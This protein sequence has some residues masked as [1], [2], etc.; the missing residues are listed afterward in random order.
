[1]QCLEH[2]WCELQ[3]AFSH[4]KGAWEMGQSL[5]RE[6]LARAMSNSKDIKILSQEDLATDVFAF[7]STF[8]LYFDDAAFQNWA[9][10]GYMVAWREHFSARLRGDDS[11]DTVGFSSY[12]KL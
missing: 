1:M 12:P 4:I 3:Q 8:A 10:N 5:F 11:R 2:E 7:V 9:I 6:D